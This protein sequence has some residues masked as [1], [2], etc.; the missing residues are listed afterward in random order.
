[1]PRRPRLQ[2]PGAAYHVT[3]RGIAKLALFRDDLDRL[4]FLEL[5]ADVV[6]RCEWTCHAYCLM[7]TH[8]HLL[9]R[10]PMAN[11]AAGMQ[12]LNSCYAQEFNRRH[13]EEGHR[14][15]RRY[16]D[17]LV[18]DESHALELLRYIAM[19]PVRA[20]ACRDAKRWPW[21][22]Y[23]AFIGEA[24]PPSFLTVDW[25][26]AYFGNDRKRSAR[27]LAAFVEDVSA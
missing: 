1:M 4:R 15:L 20:G 18:E 21:S 7:T 26:L 12:R 17:V 3:A 22:S 23:P 11:L 6:T 13:G 24:A 2:I 5:L 27:R 9:V 16:H 14:F 10:T 25:V 19:N 8:Y